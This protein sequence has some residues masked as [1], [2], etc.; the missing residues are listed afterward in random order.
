MKN[1]KELST[2]KKLLVIFCLIVI[3]LGVLLYLKE[4]L[5]EDN[6]KT[7]VYCDDNKTF[8][9][10][11]KRNIDIYSVCNITTFDIPNIGLTNDEL[12]NFYN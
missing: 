10:E 2:N 8:I 7:T 9:Y 5:N 4:I 3:F 1:F 11:G 12:I 6:Y